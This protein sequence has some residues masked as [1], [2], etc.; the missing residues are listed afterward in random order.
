MVLYPVNAN[1]RDVIG[2]FKSHSDWEGGEGG[3]I[4]KITSEGTN[5]PGVSQKGPRISYL[6][7]GEADASSSQFVLVDEQMFRPETLF[8]SFLPGMDMPVPIGPRTDLSSGRVSI[9][10][11]AGFFLTDHF[12]LALSS[13][14]DVGEGY[15]EP[16]EYEAGD[17]MVCFNE[18]AVVDGKSFK[19]GSLTDAATA[20]L[21]GAG[22][23][24][25][26]IMFM[27]MVD[28]VND[29]FASRVQPRPVDGMF[30]EGPR[31]LIYQV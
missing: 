16:T 5:V 20:G 27:Q 14:A 12:A 4:A 19:R 1:E 26:R 13:E 23:C 31:I 21:A 15:G 11:N 6:A 18:D 9:W 2:F 30:K 29:L 8:G 25:T 24:A 28:D 10:H 7:D 3:L 22:T 17:M